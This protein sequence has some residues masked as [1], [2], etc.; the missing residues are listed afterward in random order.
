MHRHF[1]KVLLGLLAITLLVASRWTISLICPLLSD[2]LSA[3]FLNLSLYFFVSPCP[4]SS[5][6]ALIKKKIKFS[7]HIRKFR[8]S[9]IQQLQSHKW[10][11]ASS[12]MMKYNCAF[13]HILGSPPSSFRTLQLLHSAFPYIYEENFIF[14]F[15]S[16]F[17][18]S[19]AIRVSSSLALTTSFP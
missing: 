12:Y 5:V 6:F 10:L 16:A 1:G 11:P 14:F 15:I 3:L 18:L 9:E 4:F 17:P 7:S 8:N 19:V 13:P 2:H